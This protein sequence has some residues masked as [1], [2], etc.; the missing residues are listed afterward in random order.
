[1]SNEFFVAQVKKLFQKPL[2]KIVKQIYNP[3][4]SV[5]FVVYEKFQS[6]RHPLQLNLTKFL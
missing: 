5:A 6:G 2:N 4:F 3:N 1:L